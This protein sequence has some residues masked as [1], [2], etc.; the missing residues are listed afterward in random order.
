M[1]ISLCSKLFI[2]AAF[3]LF[4][5]GT[6]AYASDLSIVGYAPEDLTCIDK[7]IN[8]FESWVDKHGK[9]YKTLEEKLHR[10]EI[11][12]DNLKHIDERNKAV[13]NYWLGL[14]EFSDLSH[15]EFKQ[16][17]LGLKSDQIPKRDESSE[18]FKYRDFVDL[19]KSV[20]WRKKGAVTR[21]KNQGQCGTYHIIFF[22]MII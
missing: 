14:N 20:D 11:F 4:Y 13:S 7:L 22:F 10:F 15:D 19:P 3:A 6:T 5:T 9:M 8:L 17:F 18:N 1:T 16:K 21:V 2:L 12:K